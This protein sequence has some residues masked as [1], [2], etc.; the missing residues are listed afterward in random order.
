MI[1]SYYLSKTL[2][3]HIWYKSEKDVGSVFYFLLPC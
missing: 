2:E 1:I 3:G